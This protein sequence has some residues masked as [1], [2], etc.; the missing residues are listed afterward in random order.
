MQSVQKIL[1]ICI[2]KLFVE[3]Y[4]IAVKNVLNLVKYLQ[5]NPKKITLWADFLKIRPMKYFE[6]QIFMIWE[7]SPKVPHRVSLDRIDCLEK[8]L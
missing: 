2:L 1:V 6:S 5:Q 7:G 8:T 4:G 3:K